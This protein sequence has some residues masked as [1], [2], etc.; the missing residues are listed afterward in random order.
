M[1]ARGRASRGVSSFGA[2]GSN[3]HLIIEEYEAPPQSRSAQGPVAILL[4][5]RTAEQLEQKARDLLRFVRS[6]QG[7]LD[8]G[9]VA[10]TLQVGREAMEERLG[11]LAAS[12]EEMASK[13]EAFV[14]G[15]PSIENF[16][17][18]EVRSNHEALSLF[19]SDT[20][21]QQAVA[22]WITQKKLPKLLELWVRGLEVNWSYLYASVHPPRM[23]LP[24]YPFARERYWVDVGELGPAH[25]AAGALLHPLLHR[26]TS[27]FNEQS[28]ASTFTGDEFFLIDHQVKVADQAPGKVL[29]GVAYLEM[30]RA[31]VEQ[32]LPVRPEAAVLEL[33]NIA[34]VQPL[35]VNG[36]TQLRVALSAD[37]SHG[38]IYKVYSEETG[39]QIVH[40]QGLAAWSRQPADPRLRSR[41]PQRADGPGAVRAR[42]HL[43]CLRLARSDLWA[44]LSNH[45]LAPSWPWSGIGEAS[46]ARQADRPV[47][48]LH[49]APIFAGRRPAG[50]GG[51]D[52]C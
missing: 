26:N 7:E 9:A 14:S 43:S 46:I 49:P 34:W 8:L 17:Q 45:R 29:P 37:D 39:Q 20:D 21:L 4:S 18:G 32:A 22:R 10:Y 1:G 27:T 12:V 3:A 19:N 28:Y 6:R 30:A 11:L 51:T 44:L 25:V 47:T 2:G 24:T 35:V 40:C 48:F 33:Q 42:Q 52:R 50:C 15:E 13:L 41:A 5:A 36:E 23:C 16:H 38:V 31:A